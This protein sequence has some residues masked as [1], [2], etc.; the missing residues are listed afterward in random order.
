MRNTHAG[1]APMVCVIAP[2]KHLPSMNAV[3]GG[4][5]CSCMCSGIVREG[6]RLGGAQKA[7]VVWVCVVVASA[8][9]MYVDR[10]KQR[11]ASCISPWDNCTVSLILR[12]SPT[13]L[14]RSSDLVPGCRH[15]QSVG[16]KKYGQGL[17]T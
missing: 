3:S 4:G 17:H 8:G 10:L 1:Y 6:W 14:T 5:S 12:K 11:K 9:C 7:G 16:F 2:F 13:Q 15:H